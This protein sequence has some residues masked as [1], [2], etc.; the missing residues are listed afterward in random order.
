[1][2]LQAG[3]KGFIY[4]TMAIVTLGGLFALT[5]CLASDDPPIRGAQPF[6]VDAST[7]EK[8]LVLRVLTS[9]GKKKLELFDG[10]FADGTKILESC[11]YEWKANKWIFAHI[12]QQPYKPDDPVRMLSANSFGILEVIAP[13]IIT[14]EYETDTEKK[15]LSIAEVNSRRFVV[16]QA[17]SGNK[18]YYQIRGKGKDGEV[19][20]Q[21]FHDNYWERESSQ[22]LYP[23]PWRLA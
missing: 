21:L 2:H 7:D 13:E 20:W 5:A 14:V 3:L 4:L 19:L 18:S 9:N 15:L 11:V 1:M 6:I 17:E 23:L 8:D 12:G 10:E 22:V 16:F